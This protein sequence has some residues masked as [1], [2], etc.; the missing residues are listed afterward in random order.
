MPWFRKI[1]QLEADENSL[2]SPTLPCTQMKPWEKNGTAELQALSALLLQSIQC[3]GQKDLFAFN[4]KI[5]QLHQSAIQLEALVEKHQRLE[6]LNSEYSLLL[7]QTRSI[8][9]TYQEALES[10]TL[11]LQ[12]SDPSHTRVPIVPREM[13]LEDFVTLAQ[14]ISL[15]TWAPPLYQ[16]GAPLEPFKPPVPTEDQMRRSVLYQAVA[17]GAGPEGDRDGEG[18]R[19]DL[20]SEHHLINAGRGREGDVQ[21]QVESDLLNVDL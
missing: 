3:L 14:N 10:A 17:G 19:E 21:M 11:L 18:E 16:P 6:A 5:L 1:D 4:Q 15:T 8:E 7:Q 13:K 9:Q 2:I 20:E 12:Q